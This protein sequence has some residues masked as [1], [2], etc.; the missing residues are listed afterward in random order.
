M[1]T[2]RHTLVLVTGALSA[3]AVVFLGMVLTQSLRPS[4]RA[5][6]IA[7]TWKSS[8]IEKL[9]RGEVRMIEIATSSR[10]DYYDGSWTALTGK[11]HLVIRDY[12]GE[13][14][15]YS[16][17]TWEGA[18]AMPVRYWGQLGEGG[19]EEFGP[20]LEKG[21][22]MPGSIIQCH[23]PDLSGYPSYGAKWSLTGE[24]LVGNFPDLQKIRCSA[25]NASEVQCY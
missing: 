8:K 13:Y 2:H 14:Y 23:K 21:R 9:D 10:R 22:L 4:D 15:G 3:G 24:S 1:K 12:D 18:I 6:S 11:R 17:P 25:I 19:C 16:L 7:E 5:V 20:T